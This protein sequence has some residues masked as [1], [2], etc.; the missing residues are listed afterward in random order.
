[1]PH[2]VDE[3]QQ[4]A[5]AAI[6]RMQAAALEARHAHARAELM[7]HMV[8]TARKMQDVPRPQAIDTVVSEWMAAWHLDRAA[9]PHVA[10]EMEALTAAFVDDCRG[11]SNTT[12]SHLR[13]ACASLDAALARE[14]TTISDQMAWRSQCAHRWWELVAPTPLDLPGA[15]PRP[16]MP[17]LDITAPFWASGCPDFCD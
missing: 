14:G 6:A 13:A 4:Q 11:A 10:Q 1:M 3:L 7:R 8:A 15:K 17:A 2:F 9:W 12:D 5:D 16:A